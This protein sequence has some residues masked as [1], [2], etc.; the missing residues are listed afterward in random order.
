MPETLIVSDVVESTYVDLNGKG[1]HG[2]G[3]AKKHRSQSGVPGE[4]GEES[5]SPEEKSFS[6]R[7]RRDAGLSKRSKE[8]GAGISGRA[9]YRVRSVS[10]RR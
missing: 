8:H 5:K 1:H 9:E 10:C 3:K 2:Q 7:F 4:V 6:G